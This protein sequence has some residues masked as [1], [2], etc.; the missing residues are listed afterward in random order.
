MNIDLSWIFIGLPLA[1]ILGWIASKIDL[2]QL[3]IENR[4]APKSYFKGLNYLLNDEQDKAIEAFV[5]AVQLDSDT[6]ELHFALGNLFR[7]RGEFDKCVRVHEHLIAR[8]DLSQADR[9]RAQ[10]ALALDFLRAGLLDRAETALK[11]LSHSEFS[12][13]ADIA[14]LAIFERTRDWEQA[15]TVAHR[16]QQ[17][18]NGDFS[19][20]QS[21][22]LCEQA[23][24]LVKKK[25]YA[26]AMELLE[27]AKQ[28]APHHVRPKIEMA[29]LLQ[30][31]L[32]FTKSFEI[33]HLLLSTH[34][35]ATPLIAMTYAQLAYELKICHQAQ[36][37]L[38]K[39]Q[40]KKQ[41][42][43]VAAALDWLSQHCDSKE[44]KP[45]TDYYLEHLQHEPSLIAAGR[46]LL[47]HQDKME[48]PILEPICN[49]ISKASKPLLKYRCSSC[50]FEAQNH[51]WNCPGCQSWDSYPSKRIEEL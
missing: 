38:E 17:N 21:H 43:D 1:F 33:L 27:Q 22:Y 40:Q 28:L 41:S 47:S 15:K 29:Q 19:V 45:T 5:E 48:K 42:L 50:G 44:S 35:S 9:D 18:G 49:A 32:E 23:N 46:W 25:N 4:Q 37:N 26:Q 14:L 11:K 6:A 30:L 31:N 39:I 51:Y 34:P 12:V 13:T 20:R 10:H 16:L 8:A 36:A 2:Q 24:A 3:R 7:R